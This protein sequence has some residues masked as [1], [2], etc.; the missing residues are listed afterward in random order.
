CRNLASKIGIGQS[1]AQHPHFDRGARVG[2]AWRVFNNN[3]TVLR[4]G[5]GRFIESLLSGNA[6]DG[7]SVGASDVA[8]FS[9]TFGANGQPTLKAPYSYPNN[10][11]VQGSQFFDLAAEVHFKD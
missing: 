8:N 11:A 9:Q 3:K 4:G 10:I 1:L 2:F 6:I 5:Y 7:W